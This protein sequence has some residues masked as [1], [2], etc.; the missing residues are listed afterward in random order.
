M[1]IFFHGFLSGSV[2]SIVG[3]PLDTIKTRLQSGSPLQYHSLYK[4][5]VPS[6][7][8]GCFQNGCL[9][10]LE[11]ESR[12][13]LHSE[14]KLLSGFT[15]GLITSLLVSPLE[16]WKC[17]AQTEQMVNYKRINFKG[18]PWTMARD[19]FGFSSYFY[20]YE[21]FKKEYNFSIFW[22]GGLAG[23]FSWWVSYPFDYKK[24]QIQIGKKNVGK[25]GLHWKGLAIVS[26]RA[27][28]VNGSLFYAYEHSF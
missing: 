18:L 28:L 1:D 26:L 21:K 15:S 20:L 19:G 23:M 24:T 9:F 3:H 11:N 5:F 6:L 14:N 25:L 4:G 2:Q 27:F 10:F 8:S 17:L 16:Q 13:C 12:I 7:L 22:A